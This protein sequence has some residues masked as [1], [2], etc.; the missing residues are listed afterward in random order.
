MIRGFAPV[1]SQVP[2]PPAA[3]ISVAQPGA[4]RTRRR[5]RSGCA[6]A[7][8][9]LRDPHVAV[10]LE[11]AVALVAE[12]ARAAA[13]PPA[14]STCARR[15]RARRLECRA[16]RRGAGRRRSR[17]AR[18]SRC[19]PARAAAAS[20]STFAGVVDGDD[21]RWPS[22]A[23]R[24]SSAALIGPTTWLAIEDVVD[25]G[26]DQR[27]RLPD[28]GRRD[29][30]RAG[31]DLQLREHRALVDLRVRPQR[32]RHRLHPLA[33][34]R[35]C[36]GRTRGRSRISAGVGGASRG[37][38]DQ[39]PGGVE[40]AHGLGHAAAPAGSGRL[41]SVPMVAA[42][43]TTTA[44]ISSGARRVRPDGRG[45]PHSRPVPAGVPTGLITGSGD[46]VRWPRSV[47]NARRGR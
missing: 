39:P 27:A 18:R 23:M 7:A 25:A 21:R 4:R 32:R 43:Y 38:A 16:R 12:Q 2:R 3:T 9:A 20:S 17:P 34:S 44:G 26:V 10:G 35:R 6:L 36:S 46:V 8:C 37:C 5:A 41:R 24:A 42:I 31:V 22:L 40:P 28:V 30:D 29:A 1:M 15:A 45:G 19:P 14:P 33:P 13:A 11:H 47:S